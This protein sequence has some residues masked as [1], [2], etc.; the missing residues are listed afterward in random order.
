MLFSSGGFLGHNKEAKPAAAKIEEK[1]Y[2][3]NIGFDDYEDDWDLEDS[4]PKEVKKVQEKS[5]D[6][7][8]EGK[9]DDDMN[10]DYDDLDE[11]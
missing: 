6:K 3:K 8:K 5:D 11:F 10:W 1:K 7:K 2:G 9:E 4:S